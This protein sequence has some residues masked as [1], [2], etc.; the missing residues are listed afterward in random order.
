MLPILKPVAVTRNFLH[1]V[2]FFYNFDSP[3][4]QPWRSGKTAIINKFIIMDINEYREQLH[5]LGADSIKKLKEFVSAQ[6]NLFN[7]GSKSP[8]GFIDMDSNE[9]VFR[10]E[11]AWKD[12]SAKYFE[13]LRYGHDCFAKKL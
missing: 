8:H 5:E 9:E 7:E 13:W 4:K 11:Q 1:A 6:N 2:V 10:S 12:A 3:Y